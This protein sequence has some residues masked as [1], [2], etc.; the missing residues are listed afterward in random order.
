[1]SNLS[2]TQR[3]LLSLAIE[4]TQGRIERFPQGLSGS[5]L[6]MSLEALERKG[7]ATN[8]GHG[9]WSVTPEG[10]KA[11]G[12]KHPDSVEAIAAEATKAH[13][14]LIAVSAD[15]KLVS[16]SRHKTGAPMALEGSH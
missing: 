9:H 10:Y 2:N 6:V 1:M 5:A 4:Q 13:T 12:H 3:T 15:E 11:M 16:I 14:A 8:D 7:L